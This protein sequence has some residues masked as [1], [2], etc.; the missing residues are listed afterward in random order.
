MFYVYK[1]TNI[2]N[3]KVYIGKTDN[4]EAR[5][6]KHL[7]TAAVKDNNYMI[8]HKSIEKYGS[9][10]F[11]I[12]IIEK[13]IDESF[14]LDRERYWIDHFKSNVSKF[15]NDFGYNLTDGGEGTSGLLWSEDSK[16]KIR[17]EKNHNFD[18]NISQSMKE[19]NPDIFVGIN[20]GFY[21]KK[22]SEETIFFLKNR[23]ISDE[24]RRK[25]SEGTRGSN[26]PFA[27][28]TEEN[29]LIIRK[30]FS[31]GNSQANIAK[32]FNVKRNTINQIVHRKRWTHI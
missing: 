6:K 19:N 31:E 5:L 20:N 29:V 3:N 9:E 24:Q 12:E 21:G 32:L 10:N 4:I 25:S 11:S 26:S 15:G 23:E 14:I 7:Y 22:H 13:N 2:I 17:G 18:K 16:N 28:L 27:K 30:M 8:L 1:I